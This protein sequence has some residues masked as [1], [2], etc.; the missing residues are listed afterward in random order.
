[1]SNKNTKPTI[2][3]EDVVV[4]EAPV[5]AA[6]NTYVLQEGDT[7]ASLGVKFGKGYATAVEL[8]ALN[9]GKAPVP[10]ETILVK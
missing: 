3:V 2:L 10:G 6:S 8:M 4:E 1:M 9:G 5:A 7:W